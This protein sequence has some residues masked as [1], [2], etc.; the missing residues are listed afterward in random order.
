MRSGRA[1]QRAIRDRH[2]AAHEPGPTRTS[3]PAPGQPVTVSRPRPSPASA[4]TAGHLLPERSMRGLLILLARVLAT[5]LDGTGPAGTR[6]RPTR[7]H[8]PA[9]TTGADPDPATENWPRVAAWSRPGLGLWPGLGFSVDR[10]HLV[11]AHDLQHP[12]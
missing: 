6:P 8:R 2:P 11:C 5:A 12:R 10:D 3:R 4:D 9:R 1:A 7:V